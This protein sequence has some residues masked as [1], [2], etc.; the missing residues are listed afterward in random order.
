MKN[1]K[2]SSLLLK[3]KGVE[4]LA[5]LELM[6]KF[7]IEEESFFAVREEKANFFKDD[8]MTD[9]WIKH[10]FY[11]G[12]WGSI[13]G[14]VFKEAMKGKGNSNY[15]SLP[16]ISKHNTGGDGYLG[17]T[18]NSKRK[19]LHRFIVECSMQAEIPEKFI[20]DHKNNKPEDNRADN[21]QLLTTTQNNHKGIFENTGRTW[22]ELWG[23][24][25]MTK[26]GHSPESIASL[27]YPEDDL[28]DITSEVESIL[29]SNVLRKMYETVPPHANPLE[30]V[31]TLWEEM[32]RKGLVSITDRE[33]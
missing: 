15:P 9:E 30:E 31:F 27:R 13:Q 6:E 25:E 32:K 29:A 28:K 26:N 5:T 12:Y 3:V 21:L 17:V 16:K 20:V 10:P 14:R 18:V 4:P 22:A 7:G 19:Y 2:Y 33:E 11:E 8:V 24:F 1:E 23:I